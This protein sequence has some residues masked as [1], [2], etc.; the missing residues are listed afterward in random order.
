[1]DPLSKYDLSVKTTILERDR[2]IIYQYY[3]TLFTLPNWIETEQVSEVRITIQVVFQEEIQIENQKENDD[4]KPS[5]STVS[6]GVLKKENKQF[7]GQK[8]PE[9]WQTL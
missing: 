8:L 7:V 5:N 1:M 4:N 9:V 6:T 2:Y 3:F